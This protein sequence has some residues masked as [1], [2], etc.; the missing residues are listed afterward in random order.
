VKIEAMPDTSL[1]IQV[2][3]FLPPAALDIL[4]RLEEERTITTPFGEVGPIAQRAARDN[5]AVWVQPYTGSP[6]RT[7]PRATIHAAH[8]LGVRQILAWDTVVAV[9]PTI[10]RGQLAVTTDYID[11]TRRQPTTFAG[12]IVS[13]RPDLPSRQRAPFCPHLI[14]ALRQALPGTVDVLYVGL[15]GPRRETA[16]EAHMFQRWGADVLGYNLVPEVGLAS[17]LGLC[18]AGLVTVADHSMELPPVD[19][20]GEVRTALGM[21]IAALPTF[22]ELAAQPSTCQC[23]E[24]LG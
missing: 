12:T 18:Y 1:L 8:I 2:A 15:D 4:G 13:T 5:S 24:A 6:V 3:V 14:D 23:G 20:H 7:D 11:W 10:G 19:P 9:N 16:A 21:A 22:I 17:E